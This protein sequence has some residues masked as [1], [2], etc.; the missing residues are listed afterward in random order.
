MRGL[1]RKKVSK[2]RIRKPTVNP[3]AILS[4]SSPKPTVNPRAILS[5]SSPKPTKSAKSSRR[6]VTRQRPRCAN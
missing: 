5:K 6:N 4:K 2:A 1:T 3:R